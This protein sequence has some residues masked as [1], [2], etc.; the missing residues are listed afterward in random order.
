MKFATLLSMIVCVGIAH[1]QQPDPD[2]AMNKPSKR[3]WD[4]FMALNQ[5]ALDAQQHGRGVPDSSKRVGDDGLTV[6]ETWKSAGTEVFLPDGSKPADW[7][8]LSTKGAPIRAKTFDVPKN[9]I[10]DAIHKGRSIE[11]ALS[12]M[13]ML[14]VEEDG[15]FG[16]GGGETRMNKSTFDFIVNNSLY[17]VEGQEKLFAEV[18][19]GL[20]P[21]LS[22]PTDSIEVKAMWIPLSADDLKPEGKGS[23]Y[24]QGKDANNQ[25]YGLVA[26]HVIT[27]DIPNWFWCSFRQIEGPTP[28]I[29]SVDTY[30]RPSAL[31]GTKWQYYELSGTQTEF[32]D[33]IGRPTLLSDPHIES[34]FERSSCI[35]C[36]ALSSIGAAGTL[37]TGDR[38]RFFGLPPQGNPP[39]NDLGEG[40]TPIG[41]PRSSLFFDAQG[42]QKYIQL[43]FIYSLHFRARRATP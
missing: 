22:F 4:L 2:T 13:K 41:M 14:N 31:N 26:L 34:G 7:N 17:N 3:A 9:K 30:G 38:L 27:K 40:G 29:P 15:V 12:P 28:Q 39:V 20:R 32:V 24:H 5:P 1:A 10:L 16:E 19:A 36:H 21:A 37:P 33:S 18:T 23:H 35:S 8:D 43:D 42:K 25:T 6:W 11:D